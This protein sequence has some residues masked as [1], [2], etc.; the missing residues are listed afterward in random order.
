M[1]H[2]HNP[3]TEH[4]RKRQQVRSVPCPK[5]GAEAYRKCIG[6]R[7]KARAASH[8]ERWAAYRES[9]TQEKSSES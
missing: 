7:I 9:Q 1:S 3:D 8:K 4:L 2:G 5:C 6:V